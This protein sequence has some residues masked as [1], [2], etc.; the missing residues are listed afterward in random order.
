MAKT[1]E[2]MD[3]VELHE[4]AWGKEEYPARPALKDILAARVVAFWM[5]VGRKKDDREILTLHDGPEAINLHVEHLILHS[6]APMPERRL[7]RFFVD[8]KEVRITGISV[9]YERVE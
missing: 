5:P 9:K 7:V 4:R 8:K 3:Y 6:R 1:R 2:F